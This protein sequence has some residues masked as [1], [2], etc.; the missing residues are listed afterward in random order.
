LA[1]ATAEIGIVSGSASYLF[2]ESTWSVSASDVSNALFGIWILVMSRR[3]WN[4]AA[5]SPAT[6]VERGGE[7]VG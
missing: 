6:L 1:V 7:L 4:Y 2:G 3:L 5:P